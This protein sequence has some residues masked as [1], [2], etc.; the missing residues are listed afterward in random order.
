MALSFFVPA[1]EKQDGI[2]S[3][4]IGFELQAR[5]APMSGVKMKCRG[6]EEHKD[7]YVA[8]LG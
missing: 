1:C 2:V 7:Q 4:K 8:S 5:D 6:Y 3:K